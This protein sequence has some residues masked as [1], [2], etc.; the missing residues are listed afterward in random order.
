MRIVLEV[1][2]VMIQIIVIDVEMVFGNIN[3]IIKRLKNYVDVYLV[4]IVIM[5]YGEEVEVN[6]LDVIYFEDLEVNEVCIVDNAI[7]MVDSYEVMVDL[8]LNVVIHSHRILKK[9]LINFL[10]NGV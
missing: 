10:S 3:D 7:Y 1:L 8:V 2:Y 6:V 4:L 5:D 9:H